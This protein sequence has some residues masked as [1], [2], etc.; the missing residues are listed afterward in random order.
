M[1][2]FQRETLKARQSEAVVAA[3]AGF[4]EAASCIEHSISWND[5]DE[6]IDE[7]GDDGDEYHEDDVDWHTG[8]CDD[9]LGESAYTVWVLPQMTQNF[10]NNSMA[11]WKTLMHPHLKCMHQQLARSA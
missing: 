2:R 6:Q 1:Q 8:D 3:M 4:S 7:Y 11:T 5:A 9:E 10:F